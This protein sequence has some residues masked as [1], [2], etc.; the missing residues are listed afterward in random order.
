MLGAHEIETPAQMMNSLITQ[1]RDYLCKKEARV[2][3]SI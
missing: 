2:D 1:N 3:I